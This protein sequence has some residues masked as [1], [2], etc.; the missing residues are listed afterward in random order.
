MAKRKA[1]LQQ[2]DPRAATYNNDSLINEH[3]ATSASAIRSAI[4]VSA[5]FFGKDGT[6]F[7]LELCCASPLLTITKNS[8]SDFRQKCRETLLNS[9]VP[10]GEC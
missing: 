7:F 3:G 6:I 1:E 4:L 5:V 10:V 9:A 8:A 2:S